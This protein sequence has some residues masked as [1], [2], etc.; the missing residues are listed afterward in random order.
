MVF[1][2]TDKIYNFAS[3]SNPVSSI[4]CLFSQNETTILV[5]QNAQSKF[6]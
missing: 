4:I 5:W 1:Q 2:G 3:A 6:R